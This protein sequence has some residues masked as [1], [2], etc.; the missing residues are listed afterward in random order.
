MIKK[1]VKMYFSPTGNT[2][3]VVGLVAD[4]LAKTLNISLQEIDFTLA[5]KREEIYSFD[6]ETLL[7]LATPTYAGRVPNKILPFVQNNIKGNNTLCVPITTFGNRNFDNSLIELNKETTNNGFKDIASCSIVCEHV[8]SNKL[9]SN[10][11]NSDDQKDIINFANKICEKIKNNDLSIVEVKG[12]KDYKAYYQP[13]GIDNRPAIFLKAKPE[14]DNSLCNK[15]KKCSEVCPVSS[16]KLIEG[17]IEFTSI[18][19][20]CQA[21]IKNCPVKAIAIKD[22]AFNSHVKMLEKN[23]TRENKS[24]WFI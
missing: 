5:S 6:N 23:Y 7:V 17:K 2:K 16:P 11:P 10:R 15:C 13:L 19:I 24:E 14:A 1:I 21:C 8:F 4:T 12:D 18:C 9:A 3:L 22:E 20:K